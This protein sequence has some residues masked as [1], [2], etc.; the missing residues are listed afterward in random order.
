VAITEITIS[1]SQKLLF[2]TALRHEEV[3]SL[4]QAIGRGREDLTRYWFN[5]R[6]NQCE[7]FVFHGGPYGN[8]NNFH[9]EK[10]CRR[11]CIEKKREKI[12]TYIEKRCFG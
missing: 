8:E 6:K 4:P 2:C 7:L 10:E 5:S 3:C 12:C 1:V 11:V 9:T